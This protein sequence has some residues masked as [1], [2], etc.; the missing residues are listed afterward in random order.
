MEQT[1]GTVIL[2]EVIDNSV[3]EFTMGFGKNIIVDDDE[4]TTAVLIEKRTQS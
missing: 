4:K 3:D 1:P 2:K